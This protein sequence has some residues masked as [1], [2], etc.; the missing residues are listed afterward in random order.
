MSKLEVGDLCKLKGND[1]M[2]LKVHKILPKGSY[3]RKCVLVE[4]LCS[5]GST[6]P[7]FNFALIKVFRMAD[8]K[9]E[10]FYCIG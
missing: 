3:G 5:G 6:P 10:Q 9:P 2:F 8:L 7:N 1:Y 4:C